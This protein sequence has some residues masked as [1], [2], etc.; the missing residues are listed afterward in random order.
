MVLDLA[1]RVFLD[2]ERR[3]KVQASVSNALD[4]VYAASLGKAVR[5]VDGSDYTYW[6]LGMPRTLAVRYA[7]RF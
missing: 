2:A 6:N 3:H 1:A 4:S 7:Y 5:D